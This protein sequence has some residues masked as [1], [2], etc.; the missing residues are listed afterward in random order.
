M[1]LIF[2]HSKFKLIWQ[3]IQN[4]KGNVNHHIKEYLEENASK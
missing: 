1:P 2:Y 3:M 4:K